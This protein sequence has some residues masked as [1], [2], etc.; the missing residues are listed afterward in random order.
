MAGSAAH[1]KPVKLNMQINDAK[2]FFMLIT[3]KKFFHT[4]R[5]SAK[6]FGG[7]I[8]THQAQHTN[9]PLKFF[10]R[11]VIIGGNKVEMMELYLLAKEHDSDNFSKY[12]SIWQS[13]ET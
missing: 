7:T 9:N 2:N 10:K 1:A 8:K 6:I 4:A 5:L 12:S 11:R 13:K 3:P